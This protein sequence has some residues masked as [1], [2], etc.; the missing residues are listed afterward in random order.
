MEKK[1]YLAPSATTVEVK[2]GS[3]LAG[4]SVTGGGGDIDIEP[5]AKDNSFITLDDGEEEE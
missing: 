3:L 5:G 4:S 2:T 1:M